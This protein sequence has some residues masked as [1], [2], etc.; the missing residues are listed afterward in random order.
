MK[1]RS[2]CKKYGV[3]DIVK[4]VDKSKVVDYFKAGVEPSGEADVS[5]SKEKVA[6][7]AK[8]KATTKTSHDAMQE[9]EGED[10]MV[11]SDEE[12]AEKKKAP[13]STTKRPSSSSK[14]KER[15][16]SSKKDKDRHHRS[17]KRD[18]ASSPKKKK[19]KK[20]KTRPISHEQ[21][22]ENLNIVVDKRDKKGL[23]A[24]APA[25]P[26]AADLE[27][28]EGQTG[29]PEDSTA[30][31]SETVKEVES[32]TE[33]TLI[34]SQ[35]EEE[36]RQ[37]LACL[38]STGFEASN[39]PKDVL[40]K[41]RVA[42]DK[43]VSSE[44]PV[45]NSASILRCG[46]PI[47]KTKSKKTATTT[48]DFSRVLDLYYES[49]KEAKSRPKKKTKYSSS[50]QN[51]AAAKKPKGKP[52]IV[53]PNAMTCPVT[54]L[55]AKEFFGG[56]KFVPREVA[57]RG[58][59]GGRQSSVTIERNISSRLGGASVEYEII[60]NP[61]TKLGKDD[62]DRVVAVLALGAGWQFKGWKKESPVDV[63]SESFGFY[64]SFEGAP[65]PKELQGWS[66]K[67][68]VLSK[69]KRGLDSV[70]YASF[71]NGLDEWMNVHKR[72][73]LPTNND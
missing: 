16:S 63:F 32:T 66:V 72:E 30:A 41:D 2:I 18:E 19:D 17:H 50:K 20:D 40:E 5:V 39:I 68:G 14:R 62:W 51:T 58:M 59:K 61:R 26:P 60:D 54:L 36:Q 43:I 35:E 69:D 25:A 73:Y 9:E 33:P 57:L 53:V 27:G 29:A 8:A 24:P 13:A 31:V 6:E 15:S 70:V 28:Q 3:S 11:A 12:A 22:L 48:R 47:S 46:A 52:V 23:G 55:N 56:A 42:V 44:I 7:Q 49:V 21:L 71:W 34:T 64:I 45:G 1:Y 38:S 10:G 67:K 37:I 4:V 65:I